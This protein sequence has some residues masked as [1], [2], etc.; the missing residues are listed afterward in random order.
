MPSVL[1]SGRLKL[2]E[3][4]EHVQACNGTALPFYSYSCSVCFEVHHEQQNATS[5][6]DRLG[7]ESQVLD[8][9]SSHLGNLS[10]RR[11]VFAGVHRTGL[12]TTEH[13]SE[14]QSAGVSGEGRALLA[15][16]TH[17]GCVVLCERQL[18]RN[19]CSGNERVLPQG[20]DEIVLVDVPSAATINHLTPNGH[21]SGR[22]APLTYRC[23]IF[24]FIQQIYILNILNMLHNLRFLLFKMSFIS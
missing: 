8:R 21:F 9:G 23:C 1:K 15:G 20:V 22:T 14:Q 17:T 13:I 2:L 10:S 18:I 16:V 24:L 7:L 3:P 4:S 19:C 11:N 6:V 5:S 12:H